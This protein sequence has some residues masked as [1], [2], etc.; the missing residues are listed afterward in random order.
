MLDSRA[1]VGIV[2]GLR[3]EI[4]AVDGRDG[5]RACPVAKCRSRQL[6][7]RQPRG[8]GQGP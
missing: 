8:P 4:V 7:H 5:F 6:E 3:G 1:K 2:A